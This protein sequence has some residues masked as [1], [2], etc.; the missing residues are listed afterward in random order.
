MLG[1]HR[2][3]VTCED[4]REGTSTFVVLAKLPMA[5]SFQLADR[6]REQAS[7]DVH[8]SI[9]FGGFE[10]L[11]EDPFYEQSLSIDELEDVNREDLPHNISRKMLNYARTRK[12]L[13]T[14]EKIIK[15][16]SDKQR[17]MTKMK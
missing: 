16:D 14:E 2:A 3:R 7:G 8:W 4:L 15:E 13:P 10:V 11:D 5:E 6:L 9:A 12:G 1:R 17:T